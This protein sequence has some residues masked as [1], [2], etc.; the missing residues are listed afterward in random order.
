[1]NV[2]LHI[3]TSGSNEEV[4]IKFDKVYNLHCYNT[5]V[6]FDVEPGY[7]SSENASD[8]NASTTPYHKTIYDVVDC[9]VEA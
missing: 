6:D 3:K 5:I 8:Y 7:T 9:H 1:M 4:V 2:A